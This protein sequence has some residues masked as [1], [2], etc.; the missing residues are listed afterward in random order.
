MC[1]G[2]DRSLVFANRLQGSSSILN[3]GH[4]VILSEPKQLS[5]EILRVMI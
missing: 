2:L 3:A 5:E 4:D 1:L